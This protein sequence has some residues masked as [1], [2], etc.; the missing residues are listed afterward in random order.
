[1]CS[2]DL[3]TYLVAQPGQINPEWRERPGG[4]DEL[5]MPEERPKRRQRQPNNEEAGSDE[6]GQDAEVGVGKRG[7]RI[8][9]EEESEG[10]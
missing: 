4:L 1:M 7:Q 6:I 9:K 2:S 5:A 10:E 8:Q 3:L